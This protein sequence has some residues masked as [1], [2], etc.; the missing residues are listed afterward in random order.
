M[1]ALASALRLLD[2]VLPLVGAVTA[3]VATLLTQ[4]RQLNS[5][6]R[7]INT[8][9][10]Q[11]KLFERSNGEVGVSLRQLLVD[12]TV[13]VVLVRVVRKFTQ[14]GK[15]RVVCIFIAS[16]IVLLFPRRGPVV[17]SL[18]VYGVD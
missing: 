3:T 2:L 10:A 16:D 7:A 6:K 11:E 9:M 1:A 15:E 8:A 13:V 17:V 12:P 14:V 18:V 5:N 4:G